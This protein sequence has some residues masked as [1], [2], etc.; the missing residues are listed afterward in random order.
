[1]QQQQFSSKVIQELLLILL[2]FRSYATIMSSI[3]PNELIVVLA[4]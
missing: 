2:V 4:Y 1:M 3:W